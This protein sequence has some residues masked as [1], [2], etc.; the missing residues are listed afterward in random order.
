MR[1][2][3]YVTNGQGSWVYV[4]FETDCNIYAD[5]CNFDF[6]TDEYRVHLA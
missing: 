6:Q 2:S 1:Y 4:G 5:T 3:H